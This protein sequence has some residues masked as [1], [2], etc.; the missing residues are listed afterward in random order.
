MEVLIVCLHHTFIFVWS[1]Y[2]ISITE[3]ST[4]LCI[5]KLD[6]AVKAKLNWNRFRNV[7]RL[8]HMDGKLHHFLIPKLIFFTSKGHTFVRYNSMTSLWADVSGANLKHKKRHYSDLMACDYV[9][10]FEVVC[11]W[12]KCHTT[13]SG[14]ANTI[15]LL[16]RHNMHTTAALVGCRIC[17]SGE[18]RLTLKRRCSECDIL[19]IDMST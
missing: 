5:T 19:T 13:S 15:C 2:C 18:S 3:V 11:I 17:S 12:K 8:I 16:L 9:R 14:G 7:N 4:N 6:P 1:L 10:V